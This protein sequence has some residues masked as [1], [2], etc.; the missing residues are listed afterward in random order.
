MLNLFTRLICW[1]RWKLG[2]RP[3]WVNLPKQDPWNDTAHGEHRMEAVSRHAIAETGLICPRCLNQV[4]QQGDYTAVREGMVGACRNEVVLCPNERSVNGEKKT[5]GMI[6]VAS[7]DTEHGDNAL[8]DKVPKHER[9]KLFFRFRR[10][11][12]EQAVKDKYG[13]DVSR[14]EDGRLKVDPAAAKTKPEDNRPHFTYLTDEVYNLSNGRMGHVTE[15]FREHE[16]DKHFAG[17]CVMEIDG[18]GVRWFTDP[19]GTVHRDM[20]DPTLSNLQV[21]NKQQ[22]V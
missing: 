6:L 12:E 7:P 13:F 15:V 22:K 8:W 11:S 21:L 4:C 20:S 2:L 17:W 19:R 16:G 3:P 1:A 5:C 14:Y 10:V 18:D 9:G